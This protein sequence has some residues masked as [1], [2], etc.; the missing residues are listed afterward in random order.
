MYIKIVVLVHRERWFYRIP[1]EKAE[2]D[3]VY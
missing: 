3:S 2:E 1:C